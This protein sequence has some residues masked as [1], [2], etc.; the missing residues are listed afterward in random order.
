VKKIKIIFSNV[1]YVSKLTKTRNKKVLIAF[2]VVLS[3][4]S[5]FTDILL[6]GVFTFL[7]TGQETGINYLNEFLLYIS[8]NLFLLLV[9]VIFRF[10]FQFTQAYIIK[11]IQLDV[12][13][14]L[15]VGILRDIFEKRNYSISDSFYFLNQL[16]NHISFFYSSFTN[17]L[18]HFLQIVAYAIYLTIS[19]KQAVFIFFFSA[20]ILFFPLKQFLK[21]ARNYMHESY[22]EGKEFN[23]NA[24]R[25][26]DN[27]LLINILQ[28]E[29]YE[30]KLF[31]STLERYR[32]NLINNFKYNLLNT[33]LPS[34][35]ALVLI[36]LSLMIKVTAE[37]LTLD[38][39]GVLLRLFQSF[40]N[41][42]TA[43][44][45]IVNSNVHIEK[46]YNLKT[47]NIIKPKKIQLNKTDSINL[48]NINFKFIDSDNFIFENL[49]LEIFAN[50]HTVII[51][52][53]GSGKSTLLGLISG[54]YYPLSGRVSSFSDKFSYVGP[55]PL[56]FNASLKENILYGNN[57][58]IT[59][60]EILELLKELNVFDQT[61]DLN[62]V[63]SNRSLSSGQ[64][65]KLAFIRAFLQ[66]PD[67][68]LLDES[69]SNLD[70]ISQ[71]KIFDKLAE[72]NITII[73]S[74]HDLKKFKDIDTVLEINLDQDKRHVIQKKSDEENF[75]N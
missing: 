65:Q 27:L 75:I 7:I 48:E 14:N 46:F 43:I 67:V 47:Q 1:L 62:E 38:F 25:T 72:L 29:D 5:A 40:S 31:E 35:F 42:S 17:F 41:L 19:N 71:S 61:K 63:I 11:K 49:N 54:V 28:K 26:L 51:G 56:I 34:I 12:D 69:T 3:Q 64:M 20:L 33:Q 70:E 23:K 59:D 13:K 22:I 30:I 66:K 53:N 6:I 9:L 68:L 32:L 52:P 39:L 74:T 10:L 57:H 15:K 21:L 37:K 16:S 44:N 8:N 45:Q 4:L 60:L 24:Q 50:T 2:S 58:S 55:N 73:N 18:N 36:S